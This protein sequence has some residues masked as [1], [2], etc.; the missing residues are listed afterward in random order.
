M[1][2]N[3]SWPVTG[4]GNWGPLKVLNGNNDHKNDLDSFR[5]S[6]KSFRSFRGPLLL[7]LVTGQEL[8]SAV[9]YSKSALGFRKETKW[10]WSP[11]DLYTNDFDWEVQALTFPTFASMNNLSMSIALRKKCDCSD[12]YLNFFWGWKVHY[13]YFGIFSAEPV[14]AKARAKRKK[15]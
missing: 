5:I 11:Q 4:L 8:F 6:L 13:T 12:I 2:N 1:A 15:V 9:S 10:C 3:S 7:K 14:S